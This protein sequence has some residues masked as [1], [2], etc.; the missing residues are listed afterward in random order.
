[1]DLATPIGIGMAFAA[2][3][4]SM[5][6]DGSNPA[7]LIAPSSL[8]LIF[9]G[10]F[11]VAMAG[12]MLNDA[13]GMIS[14]CKTAI[15]AQKPDPTE[16]IQTLVRF[17][18]VARKE[19]LLAL[20]AQANGLTDPFLKKGV[21]LAIDGTD[22]DQLRDILERDVQAMRGRHKAAAKFFADMG[23]FAPTIGIIGTVL[24]LIHVL[25]S[26][27]SP[28]TIGPLIAG[29]FTATLWGVMTANV[30][31]LPISNKLKR[32][33]ELELQN[34]LLI[35]DGILSI[36]SGDSPRKVEHQLLAYLPPKARDAVKRDK[37]KEAA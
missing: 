5:I 28:K 21:Q 24:G 11:G 10:T 14:V 27:S 4:I 12:V 1:M 35:M 15:L 18:E 34:R 33:A 36:Q 29:A 20:E 13:K 7:A 37:D 17:A 25:G 32:V 26:L 23:G 9:G 8:L 2:I 30:I 31:W 19:G 3:F 6:M 22:A 16:A